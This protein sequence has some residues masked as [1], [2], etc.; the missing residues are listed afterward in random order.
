MVPLVKSDRLRLLAVTGAQRSSAMPDVPTV[1]ESGYKD[2]A[3]DVWFGLFAPAK[4]PKETLSELT[5]SFTAALQAPETRS[6]L[7]VQG[8]FPVG[9]CGADFG[10][11]LRKQHDEFGR[12]IRESNIKME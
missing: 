5:G 1:A 8:L 12:I 11:F 9:T 4:T 10:A 2:F 3:L 6:K 7:A